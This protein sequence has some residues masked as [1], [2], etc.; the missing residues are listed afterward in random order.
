MTQIKKY[1]CHRVYDTPDCHLGKSVVTLSMDGTVISCT[2]LEEEI[3]ST[4]WIGGII[5]LSNQKEGTFEGEF[6]RLLHQMTN[7][8][9]EPIYAWHIAD[10]DFQKEEL[11]PASKLH[12]L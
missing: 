11:T 10:F 4:E 5:I 8:L 1:A 6:A 12:R 7:N 2:P 3:S 9:R